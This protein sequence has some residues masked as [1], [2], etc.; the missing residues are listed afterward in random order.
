LLLTLPSQSGRSQY[1]SRR[2]YDLSRVAGRARPHLIGGFPLKVPHNSSPWPISQRRTSG[3]SRNSSSRSTRS[4]DPTADCISTCT[5]IEP[6]RRGR[7][8]AFLTRTNSNDFSSQTVPKQCLTSNADVR[9]RLARSWW[10]GPLSLKR[11]LKATH[12]DSKTQAAPQRPRRNAAATRVAA[13]LLCSEI[14]CSDVSASE[15]A[16]DTD[17]G[18]SCTAVGVGDRPHVWTAT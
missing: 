13:V 4:S 7:R 8:L 11:R 1:R 16:L 18:G 5:L 14:A 9:W 17:A 15:M 12:D 6:R 2:I 3:Y 10:L